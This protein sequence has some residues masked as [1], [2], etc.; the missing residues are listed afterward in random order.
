MVSTEK[1]LKRSYGV[2]K[3]QFCQKVFHRLQQQ[4]SLSNQEIYHEK[5]FETLS[6]LWQGDEIGKQWCDDIIEKQRQRVLSLVIQE[7]TESYPVVTMGR[8]R[9]FLGKKMK[10]NHGE[11][12]G[13]RKR[14]DVVAYDYFINFEMTFVLVL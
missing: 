3:E 9:I 12:S 14:Y 4:P 2:E 7:Q 11:K 5:D 1:S 10:K 6:S 8:R 13:N